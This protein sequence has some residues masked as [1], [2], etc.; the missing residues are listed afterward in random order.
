VASDQSH[1]ISQ[2]SG[3]LRD[4]CSIERG[5]RILHRMSQVQALLLRLKPASSIAFDQH[6]F[7]AIHIHKLRLVMT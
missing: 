6:P 1:G 5:K 3:W 7:V 4:Q 2:I